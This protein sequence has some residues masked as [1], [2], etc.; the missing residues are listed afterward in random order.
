MTTA[1]PPHVAL[2]AR[3]TYRQVLAE[4]RF[5]LLFL[6][7]TL[8]VTADS[9]RITTFSAL[10]FAG[11]GSTLLSTL[12]FGAGFLP[13]LFGS[14][15]FGSLADRLPPR[16]LIASGYLLEGAAAAL[17]ALVRMPFVAGLAVVSVVALATPAF[18]G[19]SA[20]LVARWLHGDAYVLGRSLNNMASSGA[21]LFGLT[22]GGALVAAAGPRAA[23]AVGAAMHLLC[24]AAVRLRLPRLAA[25]P[26]EG[27][28][29]SGG[30]M[31]D[32][33]RGTGALLRHRSVRRLMF[34]QWLP[35]AFAAG[36]EG[37][38][39]AYAGSH[40][41][42]SGSY[43]ML[44][45][46]LP[47]GMLLG[48]LV[49]GRWLRPTTRERMVVP[50]IVL[51]GLPLI[52]FADDP[53]RPL[54]AG[55]LLLAGCGFANGLGL[56]REFLAALPEQGQGQAFGLLGSGNMT[57]QG[58]GPVCVGAFATVSGTGGAMAL[59]G[60]GALLTAAWILTWRRPEPATT[61]VG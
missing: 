2:T 11:T 56:Q 40:R 34:A 8:G 15:L 12:A 25:K 41:F 42:P 9:L 38:I 13:Q 23:L 17:L 46:C 26:A 48:D 10:V 36:A 53:G 59:A 22:L 49:V 50:L 55:L 44:M 4:P 39:V 3:T 51:M 16:A 35:S 33:L 6:T 28:S 7:R 20:R 30:A 45:A 58:L 47:V 54:S 61:Q 5:R 14:L 43:A 21:Q 60:L 37:L 1:S 29:A 52:G 27:D 32:S 18:S 19:T 31:R 24:A 57:L